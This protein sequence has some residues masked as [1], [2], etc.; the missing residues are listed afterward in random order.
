M[1]DVR[2]RARELEVELD[3]KKALLDAGEIS[4]KAYNDSVDAA[5]EETARL[6]AM[7]KA[8]REGNQAVARQ[9][10]AFSG[11]TLETKALASVLSRR[12]RWTSLRRS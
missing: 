11:S 4:A 3:G 1:D 8:F 7:Q 2:R 9:E 6:K 5:F 12:P 10:A